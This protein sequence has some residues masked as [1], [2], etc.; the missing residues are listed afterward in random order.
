MAAVALM[1]IIAIANVTGFDPGAE[2]DQSEIKISAL[3][4]Y[5]PDQLLVD[6][7]VRREAKHFD[8]IPTA[9]GRQL[10]PTTPCAS[11]SW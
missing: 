4:W 6:E 1:L 5:G 9:D 11:H 7:V 3:A 10:L 8:G 2:G